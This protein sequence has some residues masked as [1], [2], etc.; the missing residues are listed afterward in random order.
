M[1]P[2]SP[3]VLLSRLAVLQAAT[4]LQQAADAA[5]KDTWIL[6]NLAA[7]RL[8]TALAAP[9]PMQQRAWM[10]RE[11]GAARERLGEPDAAFSAF[12][13]FNHLSW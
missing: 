5:P 9:L 1:L 11:L 3:T 6:G 4:I 10:L 7:V 12:V 8:E 2:R 13:G